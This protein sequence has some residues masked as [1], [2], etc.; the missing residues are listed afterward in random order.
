M[1]DLSKIEDKLIELKQFFSRVKEESK[2]E[3]DVD[4]ATYGLSKVEFIRTTLDKYKKKPQNKL[5]KQ[6]DAGFVSVTRG[7]EYFN[8]FYTNEK[9]MEACKGIYYIREDLESNIKW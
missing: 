8:D 1:V 5:L 9:F 3:V 4:K 2:N 6:I 7:V